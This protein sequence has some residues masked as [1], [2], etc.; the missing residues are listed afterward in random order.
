[1]QFI[2]LR[3][4]SSRGTRSSIDHWQSF[5]VPSWRVVEFELFHDF[6]WLQSQMVYK[7][8]WCKYI[9]SLPMS[10]DHAITKFSLQ[11]GRGKQT[12]EF[13]THVDG[14]SGWILGLKLY[15]QK[16]YFQLPELR[17][18]CVATYHDIIRE[19]QTHMNIVS[20]SYRAIEERSSSFASSSLS[21]F[22]PPFM[23][24]WIMF[25]TIFSGCHLFC[26]GSILSP[27]NRAFR[28]QTWKIC[29]CQRV[30][31]ETTIPW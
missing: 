1:M 17:L 20:R 2:H 23:A 27:F 30:L 11:A 13:L 3:V 19:Y 14:S 24:A 15:M 5:E 28:L 4:P 26:L 8:Q 7:W 16:S 22:K 21:S 9:P 25:T 31:N 18:K 12:K 10:L 6:K 29:S